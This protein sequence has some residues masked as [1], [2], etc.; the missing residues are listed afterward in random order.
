MAEKNINVTI[1]D[2]SITIN[3][4]VTINGG[5]PINDNSTFTELH[6]YIR[7]LGHMDLQKG[8]M[9]AS[10][11]KGMV[12]AV[13]SGDGRCRVYENG[14]ALCTARNSG[15]DMIIWTPDCR[16]VRYQF[17][18][19]GAEKKYISDYNV[20]IFEPER[21]AD[22]N[23]KEIVTDEQHKDATGMPWWFAFTETADNREDVNIMNHRHG[24]K[25]EK[26]SEAEGDK[27][28]SKDKVTKVRHAT[29]PDGL[30]LMI[31]R[32]EREE[33][34]EL[35]KKRKE[36]AA[37]RLNKLT[38]KQRQAYILYHYRDWK[39][40]EIGKAMNVTQQGVSK[41]LTLAQKKLDKMGGFEE[42]RKE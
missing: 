32:I 29:F 28:A 26:G 8:D 21:D 27:E 35:L 3:G 18:P 30:T 31:R 24:R 23:W 4:N 42:S 41:H 13:E 5:C 6:D 36:E 20:L 22:G 2:S 1:N 38:E 14:Y 17:N 9:K 10:T 19:L 39:E 15:K 37:Q 16:T 11:L 25:G 33:R 7:S 12:P 40:E 34:K